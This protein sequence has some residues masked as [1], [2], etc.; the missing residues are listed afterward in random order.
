MNQLN[1]IQFLFTVFLEWIQLIP[2]EIRSFFTSV[3]RLH[4][5]LCCTCRTQVISSTVEKGEEGGSKLFGIIFSFVIRLPELLCLRKCFLVLCV[6]FEG[7]ITGARYFNGFIN[8]LNVKKKLDRISLCFF[9]LNFP[10]WK[11]EEITCIWKYISDFCGFLIFFINK[12]E[13]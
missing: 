1:Y 12:K 9:K 8:L 6:I 5:F 4:L 11:I 3:L 13:K 7:D 2:K 10:A